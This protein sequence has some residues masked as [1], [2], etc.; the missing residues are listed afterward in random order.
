MKQRLVCESFKRNQKVMKTC[1]MVHELQ[2]RSFIFKT[3][4]GLLLSINLTGG[5]L[6]RTL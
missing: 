1:F 3:P 4:A 2:Q 6:E 5:F